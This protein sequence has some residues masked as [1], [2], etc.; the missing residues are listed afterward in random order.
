MSVYLD[1]DTGEVIHLTADVR[2]E[3]KTITAQLPEEPTGE[4]ACW[5]I[6]P[7]SELCRCRRGP[8]DVRSIW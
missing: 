1:R 4:E 3:L 7:G 5:V 8:D 6:L 2:E